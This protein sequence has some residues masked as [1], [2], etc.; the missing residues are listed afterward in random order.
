MFVQV[1]LSFKIIKTFMDEPT[2][3]EWA[4]GAW[5]ESQLEL[6]IPVAAGLAVA[7]FMIAFFTLRASN[8]VLLWACLLG[9]GFAMI[10]SFMFLYR[11]SADSRAGLLTE[12]TGRDLRWLFL[13][14]VASALL[15]GI[16]APN[17]WLAFFFAFASLPH[18]IFVLYLA[19]RYARLS[20]LLEGV[21]LPA[22]PKI[23][24]L[25]ALSLPRFSFESIGSAV[26]GGVA[27]IKRL[28]PSASVGTLEKA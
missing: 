14:P 24:A 15:F 21:S 6:L 25:P 1:S 20:P 11:L 19:R 16:I 10:R 17:Y 5:A 12:L 3:Q 26:L 8:Q 7:Q 28:L 13:P 9:V 27:A 2:P 22:M 23:P 4:R 18:F